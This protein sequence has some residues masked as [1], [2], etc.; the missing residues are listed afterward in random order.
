MLGKPLKWVLATQVD[1][2][3]LKK[4]LRAWNIGCSLVNIR[5]SLLVSQLLRP[6][7]VCLLGLQIIASYFRHFRVFVCQQAVN[8]GP[9]GADRSLMDVEREEI[10]CPTTPSLFQEKLRQARVPCFVSIEQLRA[11]RTAQEDPGTC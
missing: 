9:R 6:G 7:S 8:K 5:H 10:V 11:R 4:G 2:P 1:K 3:I